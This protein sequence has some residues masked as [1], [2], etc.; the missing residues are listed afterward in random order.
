M[1]NSVIHERLEVNMRNVI[2]IN[3]SYLRGMRGIVEG[4]TIVFGLLMDMIR[5]MQIYLIVINHIGSRLREY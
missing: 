1:L 5:Y 4:C 2:E 3:Q